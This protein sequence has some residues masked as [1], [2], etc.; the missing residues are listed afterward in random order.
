MQHYWRCHE[1][2][3]H[4]SAPYQPHWG[5]ETTQG[6]LLWGHTSGE[7]VETGGRNWRKAWEFP[8]SPWRTMGS[9]ICIVSLLIF[10]HS[11]INLFT[12]FY[13]RACMDDLNPTLAFC[14]RRCSHNYRYRWSC[15]AR[16]QLRVPKALSHPRIIL[17]FKYLYKAGVPG[18]HSG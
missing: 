5:F 2:C 16:W 6:L 9:T 8:P 4:L 17:A 15:T 10:S 3:M 14:S 13:Q 11:S 12:A 7:I 1:Q 18:W